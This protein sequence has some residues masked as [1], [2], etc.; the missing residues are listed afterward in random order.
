[1]CDKGGAKK[2]GHFNWFIVEKCAMAVYITDR[3]VR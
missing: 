3:E 1:M 2:S